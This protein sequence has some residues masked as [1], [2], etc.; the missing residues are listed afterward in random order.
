VAP[1]PGTGRVTH[2]RE[3]VAWAAMPRRCAARPPAGRGR[4]TGSGA[5]SWCS[6]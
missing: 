3:P 4:P 2:R 6:A 5:N 1:G